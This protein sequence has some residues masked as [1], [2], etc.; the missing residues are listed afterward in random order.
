MENESSSNNNAKLIGA[1]LVGAAIGAG[2]G[3]LFAPDKGS[4]TRKK[5]MRKGEDVK[6][7]VT[8]KFN[9]FIE[10]MKDKFESVKAEMADYVDN[11]T[12]E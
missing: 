9:E 2:I 8:D 1:L 7:D 10:E 6:D 4:E 12:G 11:K 5:I 3:I